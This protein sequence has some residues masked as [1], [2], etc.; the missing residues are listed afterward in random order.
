MEYSIR[1]MQEEEYP[2][3]SDF[4]YM[5]IYVPNG[6]EPP[7][8]SVIHLPELQAYIADFGKSVHDRAFVAV[9]CEKVVGA[10]WVRMIKSYGYVCATAPSLAISV[11]ADYRGMGIGTALLKQLLSALKSSGYSSVSLSVQK[12]NYA[13]GLY[14]K[15]GFRVFQENGDE[16][17]MLAQL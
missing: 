10:A 5:A 7:P 14:K 13:V 8:K 3:L 6:V 15:L 16:Y 1:P 9:A 11:C 17:S 2:L 4:L 12:S